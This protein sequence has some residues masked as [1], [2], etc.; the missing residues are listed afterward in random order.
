LFIVSHFLSAQNNQKEAL[1]I[2]K[3]EMEEQKIPGAQLVVIK[4]NKVLLSE[5]LGVAN[6]P[7]SIPVQKNTLFSINSIAKVF[8]SVAVMQ[9]QEQQKLNISD[10][11]SKHIDS[12]PENWKKITIKQLMSHTSGLPDIE[13]EI[14]LIG[15]KGQDSAWS[16]VKKLPLQALPGE[17][18]NYNATNYYILQRIIEKH[19]NSKFVNF[20][21]ENQFKKAGLNSIYFGNSYDV[22]PNKCPTYSYYYQDKVSGEF[23]KR[24]KL[25]ETYEEFPTKIFTDAGAFTSAEEMAKW[26]IALQSGKLLQNKE[27]IKTIWEPVKLN[28]GTYDGFGDLLSGYALGWPVII[29]PN[30]PAVAPLGGGRA[31]FVIYTND[32]VSI[33]LFTNLTGIVPHEI[34]EKIGK[35]YI[36]DLKN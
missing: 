11:I 31:S 36:S 30:H 24:D 20:I 2:L 17:K 19:S 1:S 32:N 25:R 23:S 26:I 10:E 5:T 14:G 8:T 21:T 29:R 33:I 15:G 3:K 34:I 22:V 12:I 13:D 28:N 35:L 18:F 7:F 9:L 4:N 16:K 6:V 27:H